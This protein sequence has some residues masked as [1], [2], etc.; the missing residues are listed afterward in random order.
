MCATS[1]SHYFPRSS[2]PPSLFIPHPS[3]ALPKHQ[4]GDQAKDPVVIPRKSRRLYG[5]T[6]MAE[7]Q[8]PVWLGRGVYWP[9][10]A[11]LIRLNSSLG[12]TIKCF[13]KE[14]KSSTEK[15]NPEPFKSNLSA[16]SVGA[17]LTICRPTS[18]GQIQDEE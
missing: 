16:V 4:Y 17:T 3:I 1:S 18:C 9:V 10:T 13:G 11:Y 14:N 5:A 8:F 2:S 12:N 7:V 6:L 15:A